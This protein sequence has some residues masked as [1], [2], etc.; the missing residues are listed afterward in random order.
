MFNLTTN[1]KNNNFFQDLALR[2]WVLQ[3]IRG[4]FTILHA[5][6]WLSACL[7][8]AS[9][10]SVTSDARNP[11]VEI[12]KN[13]SIQWN[14][15]RDDG[16][17]IKLIEISFNL[18]SNENQQIVASVNSRLLITDFAKDF[19]ENR[20]QTDFIDNQITLNIANAEYKDSG[21][22]QV[23]ILLKNKENANA[24]VTLKVYGNC[25]QL[26]LVIIV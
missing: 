9:G 7:L 4:F 18:N 17:S 10:L 16:S 12:G 21:N 14:I 24:A 13:I 15:S 1:D 22:Y 26:L 8:S 25:F 6:T 23:E 11:I 3:L 20:L 19:F 2:V 5:L